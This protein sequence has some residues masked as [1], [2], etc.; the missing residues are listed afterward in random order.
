MLEIN[1]IRINYHLILLA[2]FILHVTETIE[3]KILK[4]IDAF[5]I[6]LDN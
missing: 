4:L 6:L 1:Y 2:L 3:N 5:F